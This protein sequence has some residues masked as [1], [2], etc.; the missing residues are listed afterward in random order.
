MPST[1]KLIASN[2]LATT[3]LS[4][5]FS[6]IPNTYT[7]LVV[8]GSG[9]SNGAGAAI[10][11]FNIRINGLSTSIYNIVG[12][13]GDGSV[14][15]ASLQSGQTQ[16]QFS[17]G[18]DAVNAPANTFSS[19]EMYF[20]NYL[21]SGNKAVSAHTA[22]EDNATNAYMW[23]QAGSVSTTSA[24]TSITIYSGNTPNATSFVAGSSFYLY[25]I[26]NS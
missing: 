25:G 13:R 8:V 20:P 11:A 22:Q 17:Q 21:S 12:F 3:T 4:T 26:K 16:M 2:V 14:T 7:D 15:A 18:L 19:F 23:A 1:Y 6:S 9:R 10:D 5:T 24:I